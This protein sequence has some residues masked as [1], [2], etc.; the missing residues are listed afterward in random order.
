MGLPE[1]IITAIICF[2]III[3]FGTVTNG[4]IKRAEM[5]AKYKYKD[6]EVEK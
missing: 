4:D 1:I 2:T 3:I 5:E 6:K